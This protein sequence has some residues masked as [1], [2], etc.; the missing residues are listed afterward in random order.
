MHNDTQFAIIQMRDTR[1]YQGESKM[2]DKEGLTPREKAYARAEKV[3]ANHIET[4]E[5]DGELY[6][7]YNSRFD[8]DFLKQ[9]KKI[10]NKMARTI[11]ADENFAV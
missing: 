9:L 4:L 3:L 8:K 2:R 10:A 5:S 6:D 11:G 7:M 1:F